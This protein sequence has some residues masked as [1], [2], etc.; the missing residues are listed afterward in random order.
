M[1]KKNDKKV[2][3]NDYAGK[4]MSEITVPRLISKREMDDMKG[5]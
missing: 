3:M 2:V 5:T 1:K 4:T